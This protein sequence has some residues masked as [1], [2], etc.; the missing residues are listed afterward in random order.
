MRAAGLLELRAVMAVARSGGFRS[1]AQELDV[2]PSALSHAITSLEGKLGVRLF[3][4]TTRSVTLSEAGEQFIA[5]VR[6][7]LQSID[8]AMAQ[9]SELRSTPTGTLRLNA[10]SRAAQEILQPVVIEYLRR[11]PQMSVDLVTDGRLVDIVADGFDAGLRLADAVPQDMVSVAFGP[12]VRQLVVCAPDYLARHGPAPQVPQD[13]LRHHCIRYRFPSG[14]LYRWEFERHGQTLAVDVSGALTLDDPQLMAEAALSGIGL[15]Y[16]YEGYVH[17]HL[18]AGRLVQ[19]LDDWTPKF[20]GLCL[21][22]P[23]QRH[24][25]AGLRALIELVKEQRGSFGQPAA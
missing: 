9:A 6:P 18:R 1:A 25:T 23:S 17:E 11:H 13:L 19:V 5:R 14:K 15:A 24:I 22:Y 12:A 20:A 8:A 21:Y 16:V 3:N 7:A 10:A 4:R 2:S